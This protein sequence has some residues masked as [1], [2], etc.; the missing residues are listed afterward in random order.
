MTVQVSLDAIWILVSASMW[1]ASAIVMIRR[2]GF[3]AGAV[4]GLALGGSGL[5]ILWLR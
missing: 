2:Y 3:N 5:A 1:L 4:F